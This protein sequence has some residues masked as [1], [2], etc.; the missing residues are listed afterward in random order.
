MDFI[1]ALG[2]ATVAQMREDMAD[3]TDDPNE[4]H[5][6]AH[7]SNLERVKELLAAG[8]DVHAEHTRGGGKPIHWATEGTVEICNLLLDRG[9]DINARVE[10]DNERRG[11]TPLIYCAWWC[12]DCEDC[13]AIAYNLIDKGADIHAVDAEGKSAVARATQQGHDQMAAALKKRGCS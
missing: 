10:A 8:A 13:I 1:Y 6:S 7:Y 9:A 3:Q 11:M 12:G 4:L 5:S 2:E